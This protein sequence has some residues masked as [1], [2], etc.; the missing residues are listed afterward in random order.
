M[1]RSLT[2]LLLS[3]AVLSGCAATPEPRIVDADDVGKLGPLEPNQALV[4]VFEPGDSIPL[5]LSVGGP[6]VATPAD[7]QPIKLQV[8]RK[9][10][11][12]IDGDGMKTS[13]D[14]K[15]FGK[16]DKPGSFSIGVGA[17]QKGTRAQISITTPTPTEP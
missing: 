15:T 1:I 10:F 4:I 12:R 7:S 17:N 3:T 5:D 13:L 2:T 11:L 14:G 16:V 9:F 6:L 8:K